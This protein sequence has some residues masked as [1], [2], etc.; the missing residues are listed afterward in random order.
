[1]GNMVNLERK[2]LSI[3]LVGAVLTGTLW[4]VSGMQLQNLDH[5]VSQLHNPSPIESLIPQPIESERILIYTW[6][7]TDFYHQH[8]A[9]LE[10]IKG[11]PR[12]VSIAHDLSWSAVAARSFRVLISAQPDFGSDRM[13]FE[14]RGSILP[15]EAA[16]LGAN[17]WRVSAD[18][19]R[20]SSSLAFQVEPEFIRDRLGLKLMADGVQVQSEVDSAEGTIVELSQDG[21]F[22]PKST[23]VLYFKQASPKISLSEP[24]HMRARSVHANLEISQVS[25]SVS[26]P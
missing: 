15:L 23:K 7:L 19:V 20:W 26:W 13:H 1:M 4:L 14:A 9:N 18:G 24:T 11:R 8:G 16:F 17:F 2:V 12:Q 10:M 21:A 25:K 5:S 3:C 22:D 6:K